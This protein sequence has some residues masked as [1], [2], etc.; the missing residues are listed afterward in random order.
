MTTFARPESKNRYT[1]C[2]DAS[3]RVRWDIDQDVL[4]GRSFDL[5]HK[6]LPDGLSLVHELTF[7]SAAERLLASQIQ[8]RTY[9]NL[10]GLVERFI[11][12]KTI[13]VCRQ[14]SL[15]DQQALEALVRFTDEELKHQQLFARV[16]RMLAAVMPAGYSFVLEP[17]AVAEVVLGKSNWAV[18]ALICHIELFVL[19][20]YRE[21]IAPDAALS[22][23]WKESWAQPRRP[24]RR[25]FPR[26]VRGAMPLRPF[27]RHVLWP[28]QRMHCRRL[29]RGTTTK[30]I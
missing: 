22:P 6:F 15:G 17:N 26:Q 24:Y 19:A 12:A 16:E 5:T 30:W 14:H 27:P 10:F 2:I 18:L 23:V 21:S 25:R 13:E 29:L 11:A 1:Q 9:A 20:H 7:L 4:R 3:R 28:S 8:G